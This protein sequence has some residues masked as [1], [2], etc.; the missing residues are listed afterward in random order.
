MKL[1]MRPSVTCV[2]GF[3]LQGCRAARGPGFTAWGAVVRD[4]GVG[5][6]VEGIG[7]RVLEVGAGGNGRV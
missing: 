1:Y 5:L 4:R 7:F 3:W 2:Q 6:A